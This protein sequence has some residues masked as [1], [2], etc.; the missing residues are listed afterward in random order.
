MPQ[1][2]KSKDAGG[3][4]SAASQPVTFDNAVELAEKGELVPFETL[5]AGCDSEEDIEALRLKYPFLARIARSTVLQ[6]KKQA[7]EQ[8]VSRDF[9]IRAI[10]ISLILAF[11]STVISICYLAIIKEAIPDVLITIASALLGYL[12]GIVT[13][14][15]GITNGKNSGGGG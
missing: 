11:L 13:G 2:A 8:R 5:S 6:E 12:V 10:S 3:E 14:I 4:N 15:L 9:T 1:K 7:K